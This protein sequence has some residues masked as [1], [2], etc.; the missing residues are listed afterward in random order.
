MWTVRRLLAASTRRAYSSRAYS[1]SSGNAP[2]ATR[3]R[4]RLLAGAAAAT[5]LAGA[6]VVLSYPSSSTAHQL[7]P[8][9]TLPTSSELWLPPS[10][11]EM[12]GRLKT[13]RAEGTKAVADGSEAAPFDLLI[14]GGGATGAGCAVDAAARGL[15]V[16]LVER[17]D[18]AAGTSSRSTKLV[19]GGVRYLE[20]AFLHLDY[21][22]Y[23]LV[24]EALH[25]R[26]VFLKIAPFLTSEIPIIMPVYN[27]LAL[28]YYWVGAKFY[29]WFAGKEALSPSF[30][31]SPRLAVENF[32]ALKADGLWGAIVYYD[33]AHNDSRM[34]LT[35]AL[36]A[37]KLGA[38][39]ANY[40]E[41]VEL[42]KKTDAATGTERVC[43]AVV[44]DQLT[45]VTWPVYAK[46]VVNATGP[47][48]DGLRK[49]DGGE[50][51]TANIIAPS[52]GVHIILPNYFSPR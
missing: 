42:I 19:H 18:F 11:G 47:F 32:P 14:V 50:K 37:A 24:V 39:V 48:A 7:P 33:G 9:D 30:F 46:G 2:R 6:T 34:N 17:S 29:G 4:G 28:P 12:L 52:S 21:D 16:A 10:R 22:Q 1:S 8:P 51:K 23:K 20:K 40:V 41:V 35:L 44:R 26:S 38:T 5:T 27:L 3:P 13:T 36:S 49:L 43:G 31:M 15:R 25:E 45:G